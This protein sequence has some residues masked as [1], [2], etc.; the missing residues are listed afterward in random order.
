MFTG[1]VRHLGTLE[2]RQP[3]AGG[4]RLVIAAPPELLERAEEGASICTNGACL[5]AVG[6][7]PRTW[8]ADL[9]EETLLKTTLGRLAPG[10]SLHLE[11]SLRVGDPLDGHLVSGH[12]DG[13]GRLLERT[14][15]E[16]LWRF[17]MPPALA[18]MTAPKGSIA[19]DGLSLTVVDC[20]T[21]WFTVALIPETV[22]RTRLEKMAAGAEVNL[23]ADPVGRFVARALATRETDGKLQRFAQGGWG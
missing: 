11:P 5:T 21:D 10:E 14:G 16:G 19:V 18:P 17:S 3:R 6:R 20:G 13:V 2:A 4:A 22:R 8:Q 12:V 9:S 1:L 23:E 7:D 15:G